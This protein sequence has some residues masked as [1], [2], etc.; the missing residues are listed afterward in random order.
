M[1]QSA[2]LG[3]EIKVDSEKENLTPPMDKPVCHRK[4]FIIDSSSDS[5]DLLTTY[6]TGTSQKLKT[7]NLKTEKKCDND[8]SSSPKKLSRNSQAQRMKV[9]PK[10]IINSQE[11][12]IAIKKPTKFISESSDDDFEKP[13]KKEDSM[14]SK[15]SPDKWQGPDFK[16]DLQPLGIDDTLTPWIQNIKSNPLMA[17]IR[18]EKSDLI[19][20]K[21]GLIN[22]DY[23]ILE[24]FYSAFDKIPVSVLKNFRGFDESTFSKMKILHQQI[25]AK[26][27]LATKK[28]E[29]AEK[30][31][32]PTEFFPSDEES[33]LNISVQERPNKDKPIKQE[34]SNGISKDSSTN[35]SSTK[36]I[37]TK[38]KD[39][40]AKLNND[41]SCELKKSSPTK[42]HKIVTN[43]DNIGDEI[44]SHQ[45]KSSPINS[46]GVIDNETSF[47][48]ADFAQHNESSSSCATS[49]PSP[50][51]KGSFQLKR[52]VK[53]KVHQTMAK[54]INSLWE[55]RQS[56]SPVIKSPTPTKKIPSPSVETQVKNNISRPLFNLQSNKCD[57]SNKNDKY[58]AE[59]SPDSTMIELD[60]TPEV[61]ADKSDNFKYEDM[62]DNDDDDFFI[63][64]LNEKS[65]SNELRD[66]PV[67]GNSNQ[68]S[69]EQSSSQISVKSNG[70]RSNYFEM[71]NFTGDVK[72]DGVSGEFDSLDYNHSPQMLKLFR[73]IFGLYN[74]RPN[75]LQAINAAL[76]KFDTFILMPTGGGKSLCYQLPAILCQG[77]TIVVSP[78]KS[79]ITDQVQK[80]T[81]L[82][83]P[84]AHL[85]GGV[86]EKHA[87]DVTRELS[88]SKPNLKLLYVTPEKIAAS[89]KF[90]Q[91]L[92]NLYER[93]L[94]SRFVIDEAHCV[95][96]WG[97]D[98]RP[99]YKR[100]KVL[101]ENFPKV[102]FM[103]LTATAT[104]RVRSDILH[105]LDMT[106]PK[107]F[108]S[109]FN[110]PNLKYTVVDKKPK[111]SCIEIIALIKE[112]YIRDCGIVYCF[113]RRECDDFADQFRHNGISAD[114]Y[115]AG[116]TDVA[117][118]RVQT[119][120][121]SDDVK[122]VCATIAF[123]MG[124]DKPNVRFV[125]H[126]AL[127]KSI[128]GYY[129][130]SGRAGRD[131]ENADCILFYSYSD[132]HRHRKMTELDRPPPS[133]LQTHMD[134]LY[135]MVSFCENKTDCRRT[136]QLNYF[137]EQFDK[138]KCI[139]NKDTACDN[140]RNIQVFT[141]IDVTD[142][143]K[144]IITAVRDLNVA[145][146]NNVTANQ[147]TEIVK[148]ADLK[149]FRDT[150]LN[151]LP[152][153]AKGKA[154]NKNDLER[155]IHK[156]VIDSYIQE[157]M[158]VNKDIVAAYLKIG[159]ATKAFMTNPKSKMMFPMKKA[160]SQLTVTVGPSKVPVKNNNLKELQ[161]KC[162]ADL[163]RD[164]NGIA[165]ALNLQ[166]TTMINLVAIRAMSQQMPTT[167]Q[168]MLKIP[169][170]TKA[171]Y[172]KCGR[173][174]LQICQDYAKLKTKL[175]E[176]EAAE[177][178]DDNDDFE[179]TWIDT[180][181]S[182]RPS[183][184]GVKRRGSATAGGNAKKYKAGGSSSRG[185]YAKGGSSNSA[186]GRAK[187]TTTTTKNT[188]T[189]NKGPG[190]VDFTQKPQYL[191]DPLRFQTL[192]L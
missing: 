102:P 124:I 163:M 105:Q 136:Q 52:P 4:K 120:W 104:P 35:L 90:I 50:I 179:G 20:Q 14:C 28:L 59:K 144:A 132:V 172:E 118:T 45:R 183:G 175:E 137:G 27:R 49:S 143:A 76:L 73:R 51:V 5:D 113:S 92:T 29:L 16:V 55:K 97:H 171:N 182:S 21:K 109:S 78:L 62:F 44:V 147:L 70:S 63:E 3:G 108:L 96:Q 86:S 10:K 65:L 185:R 36:T 111:Q 1:D 94:L 39:P 12:K 18:T 19:E 149:K 152:V 134:N 140:C 8:D 81:S 33:E 101:R 66:L 130:E 154:W 176:E 139:K 75:Q 79:L 26:C 119:R 110:R 148:G 98:F 32:K 68:S 87:N 174:L 162:Y 34:I 99:D 56:E 17:G 64:E 165:G 138:N 38:S 142:M 135:K 82:D 71:G 114:S 146:K 129:Q 155:L 164:L 131:L 24:K 189:T 6:K 177:I 85:L 67:F 83:I 117:R 168:E 116:M 40:F 173:P 126:A 88:S 22:L 60:S 153:Y 188:K 95:S 158:Y 9:S 37:S 23:E 106:K 48:E 103:A 43:G 80:L 15:K 160:T 156:L 150:G 145:G 91:V 169:H 161:D 127:P 31:T 84:A 77:V 123:G 46:R 181:D 69:V 58:Q 170:V 72:N 57:T 112:K 61:E 53:A 180:K 184:S 190:L 2:V 13:I 89:Q 133:V 47:S 107:W 7:D 191:R 100:L 25:K 121:I 11:H 178:E 159:P 151:K 128:E 167:V 41:E 141:E 166:A 186:R 157:E 187:S 93:N 122:V 30:N 74:F 42:S 115:H 54:K 192:G 125:I